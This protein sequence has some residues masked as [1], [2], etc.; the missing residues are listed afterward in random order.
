MTPRPDGWPSA[1][2]T[3]LLRAA[4]WSGDEARAAWEAWRAAA[5]L[6]AVTPGSFRVL[7]QLYRNLERLGVAAAELA[8][9]GGVARKAWVENQ[10]WVGQLGAVLTWLRAAG[11]PAIVPSGLALARLYPDDLGG[12]HTDDHDLL[13]PAAQAEAALAALAREGWRPA[14]PPQYAARQWRGPVRCVSP[15]RQQSVDLS[16]HL[17]WEASDLDTVDWW[18]EA[19]PAN[20]GAGVAGTLRAAEQLLYVCV[21]GL[22]GNAVIPV[23]WA[24]DAWWVIRAAGASLD[25]DHLITLAARLHVEPPVAAALDYLWGE[26]RAPIPAAVVTALRARPISARE[27]RFWA[28]N[29]RRRGRLGELPVMMADQARRV[30]RGTERGGSLGWLRFWQAA[31]NLEHAWQIPGRAL[32]RLVRR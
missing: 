25:W 1:T 9:L 10:L 26:L 30:E 17:A 29:G 14:L 3:Q 2:E 28:L 12:R 31:W 4:L 22:R 13:V 19:Q 27:A 7:P 23:R 11:V 24:A 20:F 16:P 8:R 32:R 21:A 5:P 6:D 18:A 15:D